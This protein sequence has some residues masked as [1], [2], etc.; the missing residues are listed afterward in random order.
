MFTSSANRHAEF[1]V[2]ISKLTGLEYMQAVVAGQISKPAMAET[3]P[4]QCTHA[5]PGLVRFTARADERHL[6]RANNVHGGFTATVMDSVTSC[7]LRTALEAGAGFVT[8]EL[9]VKMLRPVPRDTDLVAEGKLIHAS[10][11]L[12][13]AEARLFDARGNLCAHATATFMVSRAASQE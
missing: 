4:M 6:N 13:S 10:K 12:G 3:L 9:N 2:D 7:A 8:I 11:R 1:D 5:E